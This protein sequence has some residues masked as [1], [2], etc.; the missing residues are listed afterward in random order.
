MSFMLS[1][2][3]ISA[4]LVVLDQISKKNNTSPIPNSSNLNAVNHFYINGTEMYEEGTWYFHLNGSIE[5]AVAVT[6]DVS[7]A[8]F[9]YEHSSLGCTVN[10]TLTVATPGFNKTY[11]F[12]GLTQTGLY[13][14]K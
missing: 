10:D 14:A 13:N 9:W 12:N 7:E 8:Y 4:N 6:A 11:Y 1:S 2:M 3:F 5:I